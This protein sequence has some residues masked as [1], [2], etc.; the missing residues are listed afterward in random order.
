MKQTQTRSSRLSWLGVSNFVDL[1]K[2]IS[3]GKSQHISRAGKGAA[4]RN[5]FLKEPIGPSQSLLCSI[6][7]K[8]QTFLQEIVANFV[9]KEY[10]SGIVRYSCLLHLNLETE[11]LQNFPFHTFLSLWIQTLD[12]RMASRV[13]YYCAAAP[14]LNFL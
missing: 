3:F 5:P 13:F 4:L 6:L 11:I 2:K 8:K 12:F 7:K 1:E 10:S 9:G 14:D